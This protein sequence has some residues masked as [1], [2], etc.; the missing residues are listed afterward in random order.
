MKPIRDLGGSELLELVRRGELDDMQT[1]EVLRNPYCP[2]SAVEHLLLH[3]HGFGSHAV[4]ELVAG[5]PGLQVGKAL[6]LLAT[7]PWLSLLHVA[8]NPRTQPLVR[9]RAEQTLIQR[10]PNMT[11]GE[12]IALARRAHR[13]LMMTLC[14]SADDR[15]QI[16]LLDNPLLVENDILI[17][18]NRGHASSRFLWSIFRHQKWGQYYRVR[19]AVAVQ[20]NAPL[21]LAVSALVQL[22][23]TDL[24]KISKREDLVAE[25]RNAAWALV[26]RRRE[27]AAG[28]GRI[29]Q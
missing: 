13:P 3:R 10:T 27:V 28:S 19:L 2:V 5:F 15:V 17:T 9:R 11:P 1:L 23:T 4:R 29:R 21:P 7:L 24:V 25:V 6:N 16:A 8:Q 12:L 26:E 18:L 20:P 22:K 14:Q